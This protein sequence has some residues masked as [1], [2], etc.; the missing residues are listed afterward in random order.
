MPSVS[1]VRPKKWEDVLDLYDDGSFS[2]IWGSR[3]KSPQ[4]ELGVRWN[5]RGSESGYP[6]QGG[7]SLWFSEPDFL[8][9]PILLALLVKVNSS[10]LP[11]KEEFTRNILIALR[12]CEGCV[13]EAAS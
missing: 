5:G 8:E 10:R 3:E 1:E 9:K 6:N 4:R 13:S 2:A 7:N 12:E 11:A